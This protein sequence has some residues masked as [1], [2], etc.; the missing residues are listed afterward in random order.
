[1]LCA[2]LAARERVTGGRGNVEGVGGGL[3]VYAS[4]QTHSSVEKAVRI[5]GLGSENLRLLDVDGDHRL[6]ADLLD[7]AIAADRAAGRTPTMVVATV[8]T[9]S[10]A[11]VDDVAAIGE[12]CARHGVWL[13]VDAAYAGTAAVCPELR[14]IHDGV[15]LADSYACN[16]HKWLLTNFD[17]TA[18]YVAD[19]TALTGALSILP[20][21]LRTAAS[22]SG[23]VIDYRDWQVPLGRRF[24]ALK[25]WFVLRHHGAEG[26]RAH[27]RGHVA[28]AEELA[29]RI[30]AHPDF[31]VVAPAPLGLVCFRLRG[32]D[33]S[34][35]RLLD[36][37]NDEGFVHLTHT[38][39]DG[40]LT[41]RI[42]VGGVRTERRHVEE[43][44]QHIVAT[45]AAPSDATGGAQRP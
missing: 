4:T 23:A 43:A 39:L 42:S 34:N 6:R 22:A 38:R 3:T 2:L 7:A 27:I 18:F 26:L 17:C 45:A 10:S 14:W 32:E 15:D 13:H 35:Q 31:E 30:A 24:R 16:P 21:Y 29:E 12:V 28:L 19:R 9:T 20:E 36:T 25:L 5:S 8:G 44:W 40:R 37:L 11:A 33:A 41:L 1:V